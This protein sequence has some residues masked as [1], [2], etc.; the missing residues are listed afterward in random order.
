[1]RAGH[2]ASLPHRYGSDGY[3]D[4]SM[5]S[6]RDASG[7]AL[8]DGFAVGVTLLVLLA[9]RDAV[10]IVDAI[11]E[12]H[13][14]ADFDDIPAEQLA[15]PSANWP[16]EVAREMKE[17]YKGL[18]LVRK[19]KRLLLP[20]VLRRLS[21][22]LESHP[23][24]RPT[25]QQQPEAASSNTP[26]GPDSS[27]PKPTP[28]SLQVHGMRARNGPERS[29]QRNVTDAFNTCM[30][31]LAALYKHADAQTPEDFEERINYWRA[32]CGLPEGVYSRMNTLRKWRNMSEH[33]LDQPHRW[34]SKGPSAQVASQHIA[35]LQV[36]ID[37]LMQDAS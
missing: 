30:R 34:A 9:R 20:E 25:Y 29:V 7:S 24:S 10:D 26:G 35:E 3:M 19:R 15:D 36:R 16:T 17:L 8:T 28:L 2:F 6:G 33:H 12:D 21:A 13:A 14:D 37:A 1:M 18:C 31:Q 5:L 4:P 23:T 22:V 32:A 27:H 11:E